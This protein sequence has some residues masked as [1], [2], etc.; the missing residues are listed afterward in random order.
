VPAWHLHHV[1]I[2][3]FESFDYN[4]AEYADTETP[5]YRIPRN[6]VE[7][8][9]WEGT[10][11]HLHDCALSGNH[12]YGKIELKNRDPFVPPFVDP[13]YGSSDEDNYEIVNCIL[14]LRQ[15]MANTDPQYVGEEL[16]PSAGATTVEELLQVVQNNIWGHH[17][18]GSA[19]MG[20]CS[21]PYAVTDYKGRVYGVDSL[22]IADISLFPTIPHGN[23]AG[24]VMMVAEKIASQ[25][26]DDYGREEP[27]NL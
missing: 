7:L 2:G 26:L 25:I 11:I 21:F 27:S 3:T 22:R 12:A 17:I 1:S 9:F 16:E 20:N 18:A 19:P 15:I 14:T 24:V 13:R 4:F 23:P 6:L 5:P 10:Y 8:V